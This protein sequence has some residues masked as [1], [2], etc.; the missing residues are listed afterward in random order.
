MTT[1]KEPRTTSCSSQAPA[2][3][4]FKSKGSTPPWTLAAVD[5]ACEHI[6]SDVHG[7]VRALRTEILEIKEM[8]TRRSPSSS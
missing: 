1:R 8:L 6:E 5:H 2:R 7:E 3:G 4:R